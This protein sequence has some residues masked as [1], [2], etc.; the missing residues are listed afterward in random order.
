MS[1]VSE[2]NSGPTHEKNWEGFAETIN[3]FDSAGSFA[4][5]TY[6]H[7]T[8][9]VCELVLCLLLSCLLCDGDIARTGSQCSQHLWRHKKSLGGAKPSEACALFTMPLCPISSLTLSA[10]VQS[11]ATRATLTKAWVAFNLLLAAS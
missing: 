11:D 3:S 10:A 4:S 8:G 2:E 9:G 6:T 7:A 5:S 1:T